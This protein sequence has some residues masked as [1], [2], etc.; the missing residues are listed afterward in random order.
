M[1]ARARTGLADT[2]L[3]DRTIMAPSLSPPA[4]PDADAVLA[5]IESLVAIESP[6]H[7]PSGVNAALDAV[8]AVFAGARARL[9]RLPCPGFGD[10]LEIRLHPERAGPGVL[11]MAHIDT[12]HPVGAIASA[13]PM[14]REGD[15]LFGP[16]VYDMKG[17]LSLAVFA[18]K[19]IL[20]GGRATRS[21]VTVLITPDEEVGSPGSRPHIEKLARENLAALVVEPARDG[22]K[23]VTARKGVG[24]FSVRA[25]GLPS[26]AGSYHAAG[27]SAI[28][29]MARQ[30]A[31]L[32]GF[33]D[34]ARGI[35]VN[36]GRIEGGGAVNVT[37]EHC[38]ADVDL[39][40]CDA[41]AGEEMTARLHAL[42]AVD[43]RVTLTVEGGM[44]RPAFARDK[45]IDALFDIARGIAADIGFDLVSAELVG[46]G[47]DGNFSIAV[48]TPTLDGLG[49]DGA[50]AHTNHEHMLI[51]SIAPRLRL[52][53][54]LMERL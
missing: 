12:V 36:V 45:G 2:S 23:I 19:A 24:R 51:S 14:R 20:E 37:P 4:A 10:M 50:G 41:Q 16:G 3:L 30:I 11:V 32:D 7:H 22:G 15:K 25:K 13:L 31:I 40:V 46:G 49:V 53:Q 28:S 33:T 29:E 21:P 6:T 5:F 38:V 18:A 52:L 1:I 9:T 48:G 54:G 26:H 44:N 8:A 34:Y 43:P 39:R 17:G 42:K 47:S 27:A 35:T